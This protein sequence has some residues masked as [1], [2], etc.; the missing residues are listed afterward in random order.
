M[1]NDDERH[2]PVKIFAGRQRFAEGG[3]AVAAEGVRGAG[4]YGDELVVHVNRREFEDMV[5]RWGEPSINPDTGLPEF[6]DLGDLWDDV[7]DYAVPLASAA[8]GAFLP[9]IG[10]AVGSVLP[11]VASALGPVGT[12]ALATGLLGAGAGYLANGGKGALLGGLG[13]ALGAYGGDLWRNGM[14]TSE[15]GKLLGAAASA[16]SGG[17]KAGAAAK[18]AGGAGMGSGA[19]APALLMAA[20]NLAGSAFGSEDKAAEQASETNQQA[21]DQFNKP[22]PTWENRRKRKIYPYGS[23]PDYT[24]EGEREY[25]E[26]NQFAEGGLVEKDE[27]RLPEAGPY[28][29][30]PPASIDMIANEMGMSPLGWIGYMLG[31]QKE[32]P[33]VADGKV[34]YEGYAEGGPVGYAQGGNAD[35]GRSDKIEA[36]LSPGE[37]VVDAET[38]ALLGNG[39]TEAG[40]RR[41]DEMRRAVRSHKGRALAYGEISP[42]AMHPTEYLR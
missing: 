25:F 36:L 14:E 7:K 18:A 29:R 12:Q 38:T 20:V 27:E 21:Q 15:A 37:Y 6:F 8:A 41:L 34:D 1:L 11:G 5:S 13:G 35:D 9:G 24:Q 4:R 19:I 33:E 32:Y 30:D 23:V 28:Y 42:D 22:L 40:A 10:S 39:N 16:A 31:M 2:I 3:L 26:N 17:S